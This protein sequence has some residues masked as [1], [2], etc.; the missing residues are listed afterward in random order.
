MA[1]FLGGAWL[2]LCCLAAEARATEAR[3]DLNH[4]TVSGTTIQRVSL[5]AKGGSGAGRDEAGRGLHRRA[6]RKLKDK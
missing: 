4:E 5:M 6:A 3:A 1:R 2:A